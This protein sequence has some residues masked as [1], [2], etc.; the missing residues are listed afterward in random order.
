MFR[1]VLTVRAF[2][3]NSSYC[4]LPKVSHVEYLC[5]KVK[6][7]LCGFYLYIECSVHWFNLVTCM[8]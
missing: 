5:T 4:V 7:Q 3:S 6:Q 8:D 1:K 2:L